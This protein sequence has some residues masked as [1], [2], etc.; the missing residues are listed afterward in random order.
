MPA[1]AQPLCELGRKLCVNNEPLR[2]L[3]GNDD[4]MA[5]LGNRVGEARTDVFGL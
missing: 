2:L 4:W 5:K 1:I 3:G